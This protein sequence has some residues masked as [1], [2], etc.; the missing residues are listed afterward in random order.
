MATL[1][2]RD[3]DLNGAQGG[4]FLLHEGHGNTDYCR[5]QTLN[6]FRKLLESPLRYGKTGA[7]MMH[8]GNNEKN[9]CILILL[10]PHS[11][12]LFDNIIQKKEEGVAVPA[13]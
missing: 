8:I 5:N 3:V 13:C 2:L 10:G 6:S 1:V 9:S 11:I 12:M 4:G 7:T